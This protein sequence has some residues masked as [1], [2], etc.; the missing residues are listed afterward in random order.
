[1][2]AASD[3]VDLEL[4]SR[5]PLGSISEDGVAGADHHSVP[6]EAEVHRADD[7]NTVDDHADPAHATAA[8][9][10]NALLS[11][12]HLDAVGVISLVHCSHSTKRANTAPGSNDP[13]V[14]VSA[15]WSARCAKRVRT[16]SYAGATGCHSFGR[17]VMNVSLTVEESDAVRKALRSY[18]SDLRAEIVDT[19]NAEYKRDLRSE[20]AALEAA[21]AKLDQGSPSRVDPTAGAAVKVVELWWAAEI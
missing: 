5:A 8:E 16:K 15:A 17:W 4:G 19:D 7:R 20:R 13:N 11:C 6:T 9:P 21:I 1:V 18:L 2:I 10:A 3:V 12:Q 14:G